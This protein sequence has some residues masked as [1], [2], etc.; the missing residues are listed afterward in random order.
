MK[1][2]DAM[3]RDLVSVSPDDFLSEAYDLMVEYS[4]HHLPVVDGTGLLGIISDRD[5]LL[6]SS[7][8]SGEIVAPDMAL[9]EAMQ[10]AVVTCKV[11]TTVAEAATIMLENKIS[12]LPVVSGEDLVGMI[13]KTDLLDL[14]C[15]HD[16]LASRQ[17]IPYQFTIKKY[18]G[19]Q[20][21]AEGLRS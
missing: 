21:M 5:I 11:G 7:L 20:P 12:C 13:T 18:V 8:E 15:Q 10:T 9:S 14:L 17:L 16:A 2:R 6:R 1:V 3:T 4:I 19:R